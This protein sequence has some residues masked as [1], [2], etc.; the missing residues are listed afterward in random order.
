[1]FALYKAQ[2]SLKVEGS[3]L[4]WNLMKYILTFKSNTTNNNYNTD[5]LFLDFKKIQGH[6]NK[7]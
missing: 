3:A 1:M 2:E 7:Y 6:K 5:Y 4:K